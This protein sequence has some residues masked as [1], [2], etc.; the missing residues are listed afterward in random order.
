MNAEMLA[1]EAAIA[2]CR[3]LMEN[4][5]PMEEVLAASLDVEQAAA[6]VTG[7]VERT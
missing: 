4:G 1:L 5:A 3:A 2:R 7:A 6:A